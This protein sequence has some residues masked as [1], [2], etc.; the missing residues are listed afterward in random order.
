MQIK[1]NYGAQITHAAAAA[2]ASGATQNDPLALGLLVL[3][4]ITAIT[5]VGPTLTVLIEGQDEVSGAYYTIL[6]S[7]AL[8]ATGLTAL[9]VYPGIAAAANLSASDVIPLKWRVRTVI[10]GTTPAVT[11][12]V[13]AQGLN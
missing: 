8:S 6:S 10:G 12:T 4:N 11:A 1:Q 2:G 7:A 13:S 3:V 9:R 5:G